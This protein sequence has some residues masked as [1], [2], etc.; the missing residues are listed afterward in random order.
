MKH[1]RQIAG[2]LFVV[3]YLSY[4]SFT[5]FFVHSHQMS[6]GIVVHSHP[7]SSKKAHSHTTLEIQLL[8]ELTNY[9]CVNDV[10][11]PQVGSPAEEHFDYIAAIVL[12]FDKS[13]AL[14][15]SSRAPP[16]CAA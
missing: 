12:F 5:H 1:R 15:R 14:D 9:L 3:L 7:Y 13:G 6:K 10:N 4:F 8:D 2:L 16:Y 11:V